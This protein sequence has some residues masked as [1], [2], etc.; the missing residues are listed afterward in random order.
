[1]G[2]THYCPNCHCTHSNVTGIQ[3]KKG[4]PA[5]PSGEKEI[6]PRGRIQCP[7]CYHADEFELGITQLGLDKVMAPGVVPQGNG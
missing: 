6:K 4:S 5:S 2:I 7:V 1:M 3:M